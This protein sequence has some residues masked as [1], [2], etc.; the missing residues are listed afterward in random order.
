MNSNKDDNIK[1]QLQLL[2]QINADDIVYI[3]MVSLKMVAGCMM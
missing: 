2:A 3:L 1:Y